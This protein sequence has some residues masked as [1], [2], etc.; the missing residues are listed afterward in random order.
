[1]NGDRH[2]SPRHP[3]P[4]APAYDPRYGTGLAPAEIGLGRTWIEVDLG[5]IAANIR[6]I[7]AALGPRLMYA[8]VKA[9][10]YGHGMVPLARA[11]VRAGADGLAVATAE[12]A[13]ALRAAGIPGP[14]LL[15]GHLA[16][17]QAPA[18]VQ[19]RVT[20]A[21]YTIETA[22]A[23][24]A[25]AAAAAAAA[26]NGVPVHVKLDTGL[27]RVGVDPAA[28]VAFAREVGGL[29]GLRLEGVFTHFSCADE[30]DLE[31]TEEE[32]QVFQGALARLEAAGFRFSIR[33]AAASAAFLESPGTWLDM[34]RA[35]IA[36]Y[37]YYPY[38]RCRR[39][40][41]LRPA[42]S[43][44]TR[45]ARLRTVPAG[46]SVGYGRT[47][48][49]PRDTVIATI[50]VGYADGLDKRLSNKGEVLVHGRRAPRVGTI[51]MDMSM[52]DAGGVGQVALGDE[53]VIIG[54]QGGE[55]ITLEEVA[56]VAGTAIEHLLAQLS[57]RP[58]RVYRE[59]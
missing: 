37:G 47:Y 53:V 19:A 58:T 36:I 32:F 45:I 50:P 56:G 20:P 40:V 24:S 52:I 14:V 35:G 25:A 11:A 59:T 23:L 31:R 54:E 21:V 13:L 17:E 33:H 51:A 48:I 42:L 16:P 44:K 22:R 41:S 27:C 30:G 43:L 2:P 34:V 55:R 12:E 10:A 26:G 18:I 15:M 29:Q 6:A 9:N 8:V 46:T 5:A 28:A 7:K 1:M 3:S 4:P 39:S 49:C 57:A 38:A